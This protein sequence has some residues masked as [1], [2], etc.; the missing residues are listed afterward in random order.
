MILVN[1]IKM[2]NNFDLNMFLN[3]KVSKTIKNNLILFFH[4]IKYPKRYLLKLRYLQRPFLL[5]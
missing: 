4:N 1:N 5:F 3:I 2:L